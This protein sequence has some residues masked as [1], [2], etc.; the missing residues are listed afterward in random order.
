MNR[1]KMFSF[2][3]AMPVAAN[4]KR[5]KR[6]QTCFRLGRDR[7]NKKSI[8]H[9]NKTILVTAISLILNEAIVGYVCFAFIISRRNRWQRRHLKPHVRQNNPGCQCNF[10]PGT[11]NTFPS[12]SHWNVPQRNEGS[13]CLH[14]AGDSPQKG[15]HCVSERVDYRLSEEESGESKWLAK[16]TEK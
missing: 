15:I 2:S 11:R 16:R 9:Q 7:R 3:T 13:K 10:S 1:E 12:S 14:Q 4:G 6:F 8:W 5:E